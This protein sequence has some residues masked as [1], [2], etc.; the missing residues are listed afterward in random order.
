VAFIV[1]SSGNGGIYSRKHSKWIVY[2]DPSGNVTLNGNANTATKLSTNASNTTASFW[3]GDNT[4]SSTLTGVLNITPAS[5]E[6]GEL[7][8]NAPTANTA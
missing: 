6:G 2:A 7:H 5:G 1:G 3:R 4:W 8:L